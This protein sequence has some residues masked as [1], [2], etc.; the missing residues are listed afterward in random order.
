MRVTILGNTTLSRSLKF[1]IC[2]DPFLCGEYDRIT[3]KLKKFYNLIKS[4]YRN[5]D[6]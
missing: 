4:S 3:L 2:D 5:Y 6:I 1:I